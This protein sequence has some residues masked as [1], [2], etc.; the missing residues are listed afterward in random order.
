MHTF[1]A[2]WKQFLWTDRRLLL[3]FNFDKLYVSIWFYMQH[4][5]KMLSMILFVSYYIQRLFWQ[6]TYIW[7]T[8]FSSCIRLLLHVSIIISHG[9]NSHLLPYP[10]NA[11]IHQHAQLLEVIIQKHFYGDTA[12]KLKLWYIFFI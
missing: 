8:I 2:S 3:D 1:N 10:D 6:P 5:V 7:C 11:I 12:K 4:T 9:R